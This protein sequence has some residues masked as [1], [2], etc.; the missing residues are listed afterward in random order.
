MP[1]PRVTKRGVAFELT[2]MFVWWL[3][4]WQI[5]QVDLAEVTSLYLRVPLRGLH[6]GCIDGGQ[7]HQRSQ[8]DGNSKSGRKKS[9][10]PIEK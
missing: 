8:G 2:M 4:R 6:W 10:V 7:G 3:A 9:R 5:C 1:M